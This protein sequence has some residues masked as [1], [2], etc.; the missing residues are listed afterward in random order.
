MGQVY[1]NGYDENGNV[2]YPAFFVDSMSDLA[3]EFNSN[4]TRDN[5]AQADIIRADVGTALGVIFL[6]LNSKKTDTPYLPDMAV[7]DWQGGAANDANGIIRIEWTAPQDAHYDIHLNLAWV[8]NG[9]YSW[10]SAGTRP[11]RKDTFDTI[12]FRLSV[13][14]TAVAFA[15][16]FEDGD[17]RWA[18][19]MCGAVQLPAG[20]HV[21][22]VECEV[23]RRIA[24]DGQLDG[25]CTND[26]TINSRAC[27]AMGRV[28]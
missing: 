11:D 9:S 16:P 3:G 7:T 14:G 19:Y 25:V 22:M 15:G 8:W 21:L 23:V 2:L 13:D 5:F 1:R 17:V 4:L 18:T 28:R 24:Q 12:M 26:V 27:V 6:D 10:T 20:S